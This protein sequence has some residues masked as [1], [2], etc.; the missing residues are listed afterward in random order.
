MSLVRHSGPLLGSLLFLLAA[1]SSTSSVSNGASGSVASTPASSQPS[2]ATL[3]S[4]AVTSVTVE[5]DYAPGAE[6]YIGTLKDFGDPWELFRSNA[7]AIFDGKKTL[8]FPRTLAKMEA[9]PD[10]TAKSFT[11]EDLLA[12]AAAHRTEQQYSDA[13][14]FYVV[15]VNGFWVDETGAER[16]D[17]LGVSVPNSGVI[18]IFKPAI[19]TP[20][21]STIPPPQLVEQVA[22]IHNFAHAVGFVDNGVPVAANNRAHVDTANPHHCSNK[23]CPLSIAVESAVG[24]NAFASSFIPF[25]GKVI[26]GQECL[27]D[28]RLFETSLLGP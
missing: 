16:K 8:S 4:R 14:S 22:L 17:I 20:V 18:G 13:V 12:I 5:I 3:F 28:A 24:A 26:L 1:C 11:N 7:L 9:L 2:A 6:P 23:Q 21:A 19:T 27:S 10:V 25:P 15:F